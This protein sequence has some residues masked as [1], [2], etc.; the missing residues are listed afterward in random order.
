MTSDPSRRPRR[1]FDV[2]CK[3]PSCAHHGVRG[4]TNFVI[5]GKYKRKG[6]AASLVLRCNCGK[7]RRD[8][9]DRLTG[10][11]Q[12]SLSRAEQIRQREKEARQRLD[13]L[14]L[15]GEPPPKTVSIEVVLDGTMSLA[16]RLVAE[17]RSLDEVART[18]SVKR[19]RAQEYRIERPA[20]GKPMAIGR[21]LLLAARARKL[22]RGDID[23][24]SCKSLRRSLRMMIERA[25]A[26]PDAV[27]L[28]LV[29]LP[30][31][32]NLPPISWKDYV[33]LCKASR[34]RATRVRHRRL[35]GGL[36]KRLGAATI[37]RNWARALRVD[38]AGLRTR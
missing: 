32:A 23:W 8:V 21:L 25:L 15:R 9:P 37:R 14:K 4:G 5:A 28:R 29:P 13:S 31:G 34:A 20:S 24:N 2:A 38:S 12:L 30:S 22:E 10:S 18:F 36:P 17:G 6:G 16:L 11:H 19:G 27:L 35:S 1:R 3:N 7:H 26:E 33:A